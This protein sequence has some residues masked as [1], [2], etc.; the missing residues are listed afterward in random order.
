M[1]V[2]RKCGNISLVGFKN[3][4]CIMMLENKIVLYEI[5]K[6][7]KID[8]LWDRL[9]YENVKLCIMRFKK[10][11]KFVLWDKKNIRNFV[12]CEKQED[13]KNLY[14]MRFMKMC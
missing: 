12:Y 3:K 9:K 11:W 8:D 10:I 5:I 13:M 4:I 1:W 7:H 6:K 14:N 2:S